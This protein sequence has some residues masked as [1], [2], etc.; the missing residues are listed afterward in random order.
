MNNE[1]I[2]RE[3]I[4]LMLNRRIEKV[5]KHI[6]KCDTKINKE[7]ANKKKYQEEMAALRET[8]LAMGEAY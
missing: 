5:E 8:R 7:I 4:L 1:E 6:K 2:N 3:Q